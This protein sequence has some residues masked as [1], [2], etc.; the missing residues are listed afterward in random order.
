MDCWASG[1]LVLGG[2]CAVLVARRPVGGWINSI[3]ADIGGSGGQLAAGRPGGRHQ[4]S[5]C[6]ASSRCASGPSPLASCTLPSLSPLP[7]SRRELSRKEERGGSGRH[8]GAPSPTSTRST[9]T[10]CASAGGV[11][12]AAAAAGS[13][14][15]PPPPPPP[16]AAAAPAA[17]AAEGLRG[18]PGGL[19]PQVASAG[20]A[21]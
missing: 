3:H 18:L 20:G 10:R 8:Q 15:P 16:P 12:G 6:A 17:A 4:A 21:S 2:G 7:L 1:F 13:G 14:L 11:C 9:H 19:G 5:I